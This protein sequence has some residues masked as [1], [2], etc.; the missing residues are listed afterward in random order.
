MRKASP[1]LLVVVLYT[2]VVNAEQNDT[3]ATPFAV[4][5]IPSVTT[6]SGTYAPTSPI[7]QNT[8]LLNE[9]FHDFDMNF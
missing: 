5:C 4:P 3:K 1:I 9:N 6:V 7:C 2:F 8:L